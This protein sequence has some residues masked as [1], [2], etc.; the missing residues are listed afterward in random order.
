MSRDVVTESV[1][2]F[3]RRLGDYVVQGSNNTIIICGTDRAGS[4]P[5][6]VDEGLGTLEAQGGGKGTGTVHI[7]SGRQDPS[8]DP[9]LDKDLSYIYVSMK[10]NA[11]TNTGLG[12]IQGTTDGTPAV[13]VKSDVIRQIYRQ[14]MKISSDDQNNFVYSDGTQSIFSVGG[15]TITID[16]S[17]VSVSVGTTSVQV[18]PSQ[19]AASIGPTSVTMNPASATILS[20][21]IKIGGGGELPWVTLMSTILAA[22]IGH[23]HLS[24]AGPTTPAALGVTTS[25][26]VLPAM[27]AAQT[28]WLAG[29]ID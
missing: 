11:D 17:G 19:I 25:P 15:Y 4:D 3:D 20:P 21:V 12:S 29:A 18:Q 9:D 16:S 23:D 14:N 27:T 8:G 26:T 28:A 2:P 1:P 13:I 22:V 10:T 24:A 7:I 5:A 6:S